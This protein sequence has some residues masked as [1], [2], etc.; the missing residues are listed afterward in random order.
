[1]KY[2]TCP[3]CKTKISA[4]LAAKDEKV[5]NAIGMVQ[6]FTVSKLFVTKNRELAQYYGWVNAFALVIYND[7]KMVEARH[8][9]GAA[10]LSEARPSQCQRRA[11]PL[12][13]NRPPP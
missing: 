2:N 10:R 3:K 8:V 4:D 11:P 13:G 1:M 5:L 9:E 6:P 12:R 7:G